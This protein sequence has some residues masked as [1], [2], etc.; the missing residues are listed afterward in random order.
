MVTT[1]N[2][3]ESLEAL[4]R[5]KERAENEFDMAIGIIAITSRGMGADSCVKTWIGRFAIGSIF[6]P[7]TLP[8][9]NCFTR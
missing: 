6:K 2:W 5:A 3:D 4:L 7:L 9:G 1:L 8:M